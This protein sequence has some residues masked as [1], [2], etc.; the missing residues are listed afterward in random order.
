MGILVE[1]DSREGRKLAGPVAKIKQRIYTL[2][3]SRG[4][5]AAFFLVSGSRGLLFGQ[6]PKLP[7][8]PAPQEQ[9][10]PEEDASLKP[11]E[12]S[13]NPLQ[14]AKEMD[15]GNQHLKKG[16]YGAAVYRFHR[17]TLYD[18]GSGE[19]FRKL[20][21]AHEKLHDYSAAREAYAKY[22]ELAKD[23]KDA[24][25]IKKRMAKWPAASD[26]K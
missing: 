16:K 15:V 8:P 18:P 14:A 24:D 4:L 26:K 23:A 17:A 22:F 7:P 5:L 13:F 25:A 1:V 10:P 11:E 2:I 20:G 19:A 9:E 12:F 3:V 6:E 21:E